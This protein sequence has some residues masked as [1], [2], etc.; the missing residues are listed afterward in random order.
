M[1]RSR[2]STQ[3]R[4]AICSSCQYNVI[5]SK[6][7]IASMN[8]CIR[9]HYATAILY[10]CNKERLSPNLKGT[11]YPP[12]KRHLFP[13]QAL[14][15]SVFLLFQ[16][17]FIAKRWRVS[18]ERPFPHLFYGVADG[19]SEDPCLPEPVRSRKLCHKW[20]IFPCY[21]ATAW[22]PFGQCIHF[23]LD[24]YSPSFYSLYIPKRVARKN[25]EQALRHPLHSIVLLALLLAAGDLR[26]FSRAPNK[27]VGPFR[28]AGIHPASPHTGVCPPGSDEDVPSF[29]SK[30]PPPDPG[31]HLAASTSPPVPPLTQGRLCS[32]IPECPPPFMARPPALPLPHLPLD[33][34]FLVVCAPACGPPVPSLSQG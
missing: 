16:N 5:V 32:L 22:V 34:S 23:L 20:S 27:R 8:G 2:I 29:K 18:L 17:I 11:A 15:K 13:H 21:S 19:S 28:C 7:H 25:H 4:L 6:R 31:T 9:N 30:A 26:A 3:S 24:P 14:N 10:L 1:H 33:P 12:Q